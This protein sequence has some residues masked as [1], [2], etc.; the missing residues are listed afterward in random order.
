MGKIKEKLKQILR[1]TQKWTKIDMIYLAKGG[2]WLTFGQIVMAASDFALMILLANF[3]PPEIYGAYRYILSIVAILILFS[4][5]GMNTAII[6]AVS[7]GFEGSVSKGLKERI[8]WGA[9]GSIASIGF[10]IYYWYL[11]NWEYASIFFSVAAFI[12][13]IDSFN[14]YKGVLVG[15]KEFKSLSLYNIVFL[16]GFTIVLGLTIFFTDKILFIFLVYFIYNALLP[17]LFYLHLRKQKPFNDAADPKTVSYG[18][19]L[20]L[21][22]VLGN[23]A[24]QLD[25]VLIFQFLGPVEVAIYSIAISPI[26]Q[27]KTRYLVNLNNLVLPKIT[28]RNI[29]ELKKS[30]PMKLLMFFIILA[31]ITA[32]Y[33][34]LVPYIYKI[35]F[36]Q[37]PE[38][39]IYS[40]IF[41]LSLLVYPTMLIT[42][43]LVAKSRNKELYITRFINPI[44]K[45]ILLI[46]LVPLYRIW[47]AII[48]VIFTE[49]L[50]SLI[51]LFFFMKLEPENKECDII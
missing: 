41:G 3:L 42:N 20:S 48:A 25:K 31:V 7:R 4:L 13:F 28:N 16:I 47:G 9:I 43:V 23:I 17:L 46:I 32:L 35:I 18:K 33:I 24:N 34:L 40:Q 37:Y 10:A 12:P 26:Q 15:R 14:L 49:F 39:V 38:S 1:W 51:L 11:G 8:K 30:I 27:L 22:G 6:Q 2:F 19:H 45:I 21:M 5:S 36:P 44:I 50:S 29:S